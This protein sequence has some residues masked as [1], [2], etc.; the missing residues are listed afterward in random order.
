[1][2]L[3]LVST[4]IASAHYL[5]LNVVSQ[6]T[7]VIA[8]AMAAKV[9]PISYGKKVTAIKP[10]GPFPQP[11]DIYTSGDTSQPY[12]TYDHVISTLPFSCLRNVDTSSCNFEWDLSTAIRT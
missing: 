8:D 11:I 3:R 1:M 12:G 7:Q 4:D 9:K 10:K 5:I 2:V 6:G